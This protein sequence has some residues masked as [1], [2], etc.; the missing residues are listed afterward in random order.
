MLP[1]Q[2]GLVYGPVRS[3]RLGLSLGINILPRQVKLCTFNCSYCQ[4]GW[5]RQPVAGAA[6]SGESWPAPAS[7]AKAVAHRLQRLRAHGEHVDRLT[8]AGNGE[9]TLHPQ[10]AEV[11]D[12]VREARDQ[13]A[14][15]TPVAVLSNS[16]TLEQPGVAAALDRL[17]ERY[18]KLDAGDATQLRR[19]NA[20][21]VP[22]DTLVAG[23]ARLDGI[24]VQ[25]MF[26]KDR[27][28]RIDNATDL[29]IANWIA[30]LGTIAPLGV[31]VY[32]IDRAPAWPYLQPIPAARLEEIGRRARVAGLR[33]DVFGVAVAKQALAR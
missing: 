8:F 18:M 14:P 10:F 4:Y 9:P 31:H 16:S 3:R 25:S 27:L 29:A 15:G 24:V 21:Q 11:V 7:V 19:V 20:S 6:P 17:D 32:T 28:G 33:A 2:E 5:T 22:F 12:A 30:V 1:L 26:V 13:E 23:L